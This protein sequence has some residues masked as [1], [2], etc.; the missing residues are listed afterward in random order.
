MMSSALSRISTVWRTVINEARAQRDYRAVQS[1][2]EDYGAMRSAMS[3]HPSLGRSLARF[4]KASN[5]LTRRSPA[6]SDWPA[7]SR[8]LRLDELGDA[9]LGLRTQGYYIFRNRPDSEITGKLLSFAE[10]EPCWPRPRLT[11]PGAF[12]GLLASA[13]RYDFDEE[14]L[15]KSEE[16]QDWA[17]DPLM[18]RLASAYVGSP[19]VLDLLT[20]WWTTPQDVQQRD[21]NA[22]MFHT[23][24]DRLSF[25]KFFIYLTDVDPATGPHVY[26][27]NSHR[28]VPRALAADRRMTDEEVTGL[29]SKG[30]SKFTE[31][32]EI[33]GPAGTIFA[34]DTRGIHKG[35]SP[36]IGN[37]LVLQSEFSTSLLGAPFEQPRVH[38]QGAARHRAPQMSSALRRWRIV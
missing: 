22:Q 1:T 2:D 15:L 27:P 24:R 19:A 9:L 5:D 30:S 8:F 6:Q 7:T 20:M 31:P 10:T 11:T 12:P 13:G 37:R 35:K 18:L 17:T 25:V 26:V 32:V 14:T 29:F 36:E 34:A 16:I 4:A 23:D 38:L 33:T 21:G 28:G 3:F